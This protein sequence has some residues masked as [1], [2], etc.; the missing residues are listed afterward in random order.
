MVQN[1]T[2][3]GC[4][5]VQ[6]TAKIKGPEVEE[7][8]CPRVEWEKPDETVAAAE[9]DCPPFDLRNECYPPRGAECALNWHTEEGHFVVDENPCDCTVP[10]YPRT[11]RLDFCAPAHPYGS[12]WSVTVRLKKNGK[13]LAQDSVRFLVK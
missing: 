6:L 3:R 2:S 1:V 13:T 8:Y 11:W 12:V 5:D 4:S 7:W 9:S 10:G